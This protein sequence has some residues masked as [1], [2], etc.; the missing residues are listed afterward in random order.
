VLLIFA[1]RP[2]WFAGLV[3]GPRRSSCRGWAGGRLRSGQQWLSDAGEAGECCGEV[4]GPGPAGGD[5]DEGASAA[6]DDPGGGVQQPVA[7][8]F[9][10]GV[11]QLAGE[12]DRLGSMRSGPRR[13]MRGAARPR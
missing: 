4:I 8:Q 10:F 2:A 9:R 5:L 11:G 13:S 6:T 12:Q 3:S 1:V 7:E